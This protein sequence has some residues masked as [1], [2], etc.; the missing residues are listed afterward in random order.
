MEKL[1]PETY[2]QAYQMTITRGPDVN[3]EELGHWY[4]PARVAMLIEAEREAC[5][6]VCEELDTYE[7]EIRQECA[8]AIRK[9]SNV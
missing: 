3:A 7:P 9:R 1:L 2:N 5:A 8:D 4:S 6:K